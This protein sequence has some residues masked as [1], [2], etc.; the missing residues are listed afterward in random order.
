L[1]PLNSPTTP[2][3]PSFETPPDTST[4]QSF[5]PED[6]SSDD[7]STFS[8]DDDVEQDFG[9]QSDKDTATNGDADDDE[10]GRFLSAD[11]V[12]NLQGNMWGEVHVEVY[13]GRRAGTVHSHGIPTMKEFE[14]SLGGPSSNLYAPFSSQTDWELA[15][16]AKLRGP[17]ATAFTELMGVTGV[18]PFLLLQ[19]PR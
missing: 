16:W 6:T 3:P 7:A 19:V 14:N 4:H 9:D 18:R 13:P 8:Y 15:K 11:E 17:G 12:T 1:S 5:D 2:T 10:H